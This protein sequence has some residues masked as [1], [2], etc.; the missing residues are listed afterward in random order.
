MQQRR[1]VTCVCVP[2]KSG[3]YQV[4]WLKED[5]VEIKMPLGVMSSSKGDC[6]GRSFGL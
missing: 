5:I 2:A 4:A 6:G 1:E 3:R